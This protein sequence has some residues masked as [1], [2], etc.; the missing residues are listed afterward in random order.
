VIDDFK[1]KQFHRC[2]VLGKLTHNIYEVS[3]RDSRIAG[4][5]DNDKAPSVGEHVEGFVIST[6]KAGCFVRLARSLEGRSQL[7]NISDGF[8]SDPAATFPQGR[9]VSAKVTSIKTV[10]NKQ[11]LDLDLRSSTLTRSNEDGLKFDEIAVG[12]TYDGRVSRLEDF[13][14]FIAINGSNLRGMAHKSEC[15]DSFVTDLT[16]LYTPGDNVRV[17]ILKK[18]EGKQ[19]IGLSLKPSRLTKELDSNATENVADA[20]G[21]RSEADESE[22]DQ[23]EQMDEK[24][25]DEDE[26][27]DDSHIDDNDSADSDDESG[28]DDDSP[29]SVLMDTDVGFQ[30]TERA[31]VSQEEDGSD[32]SSDEEE[33]DARTTHQSRRKTA[34]KRQ[35]EAKLNEREASLADGLVDDSPETSAD[36]ERQ[37]AG[38][39]NSSELWIK[40]MAF[41]IAVADIDGAR[42]VAKRA[43]SRIQFREEQEKLNVWC[44]LL[45]LEWTYGSADSLAAAVTEACQH[46]N[47]KHVHLRLCE[48]MSSK[49]KD[50]EPETNEFYLQMCKRFRS[51]KQVWLAYMKY[52]LEREQQDQAYA[53]SKRALQSLPTYK[54]VETISKFA[55]LLYEFGVLDRARTLFEGL[56]Q[57]YP[58]RLDLLHVYVDKE[59]KFGEVE[60]ARR[61]YTR[62]VD[63]GEDSI[64]LK[65]S[66]KQMKGVFKKWFAFEEVHGS[67]VTQDGVKDAAR[68]FVDN[69]S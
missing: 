41:Y 67:S 43:V 36:F 60:A 21:T 59:V 31:P 14:V 44:A 2:R 35:E 24:G 10:G 33:G 23:D 4:D 69:S 17:F 30:W 50:L 65:L 40:Y 53:I 18:D 15:S 19:T 12:E 64:K 52:L 20:S 9:L 62:L 37:L 27:S 11:C 66:D 34:K 29:N 16:R 28:S 57:K 22:D 61:I 58:R 47:P 54:H 55:Q 45:T 48:V 26:E 25:T 68:A 1:S 3:L 39:P 32:S 8:V 7:K 63:T 56:L 46:N 49:S 13:G 6:N 51:K 38:S 5:I 42:S